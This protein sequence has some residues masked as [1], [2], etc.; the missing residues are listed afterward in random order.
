MLSFFLF[1]SES[2][3]HAFIAMFRAITH[4]KRSPL[5]QN[6]M[7]RK[8]ILVFAAV[9]IIF[10]CCSSVSRFYHILF[11]SMRIQFYSNVIRY[12]TSFANPLLYT[13]SKSDLW[14]CLRRTQKTNLSAQKVKPSLLNS[15]TD[16]GQDQL[17][18]TEGWR[19]S[20]AKGHGE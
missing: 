5:V 13:F 3:I 8:C 20:K 19:H 16:Y 15:L 1:G 18:T 14:S 4:G 17:S 9:A 11:L 12:I 7:P 10:K 6:N 2:M